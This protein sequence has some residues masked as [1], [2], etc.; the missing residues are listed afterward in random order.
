M[1]LVRILHQSRPWDLILLPLF[2]STAIPSFFLFYSHTHIHRI[3]PFEQLFLNKTNLLF[4][5]FCLML[6]STWDSSP[7]YVWTSVLPHRQTACSSRLS[8]SCASPLIHLV[9]VSFG[10]NSQSTHLE[11]PFRLHSS[12][13]PIRS[14]VMLGGRE[15]WTREGRASIHRKDSYE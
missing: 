2:T 11:A 6:I 13:S 8:L 3:C 1:M 5:D 4:T 14:G 15:W 12:K 10:L 7:L 9:F